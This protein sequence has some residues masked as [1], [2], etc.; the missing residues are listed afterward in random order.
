MSGLDPQIQSLITVKLN[1]VNVKMS[2]Q[3][4]QA[5]HKLAG[6]RLPEWRILALLA[7]TGTLSQADIRNQIGMD[8]GQIS[9]TVKTMLASDLISNEE[10]S[11]K[12]RN[13]RLNL[14]EKG[15]EIYRQVD[16]MME[17]RNQQLLASLTDEQKLA[18]LDAL[19]CLEKSVDA[20]SM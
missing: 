3:I 17:K 9:R 12:A 18:M 5:V 1:V 2:R 15:L 13:V 10:D 16:V 14:T 6:L 11:G 19:E 4:G 8:K 7:S 20:W